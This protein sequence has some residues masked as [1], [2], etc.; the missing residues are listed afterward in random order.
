MNHPILRGCLT[1]PIWIF[2]VSG[3]PR[4][5]HTVA[6]TAQRLHHCL[7]TWYNI[8]APAG[9]LP[10]CRMTQSG[11]E[12]SNCSEQTHWLKKLLPCGVVGCNRWTSEEITGALWGDGDGSA[13]SSHG[14][15]EETAVQP[16]SE[17]MNNTETWRLVL[18]EYSTFRIESNNYFSIRFESKR[19]QLLEIFEYLPSPISYLF[20][21]MA[22][23][24][25]LSNHT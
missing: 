15:D 1:V 11:T 18:C 3:H 25:H 19:A 8:S 16:C 13:A 5:P 14:T 7:K 24:F 4:H 21:W 23:I 10:Q 22:L 6:C 9:R 17:T 12:I 2:G 20:N